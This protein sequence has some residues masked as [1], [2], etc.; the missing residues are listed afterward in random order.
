[1]SLTV[2]PIYAALLAALLL[3]LS[4]RVVLGRFGERISV[5]DGDSKPLIKRMRVQANFVEY[6]PMALI[7][8]LLIELQGAPGWFLHIL[9]L[10]LLG[11]RILHAWGLGHTPQIVPLR[12]LGM[13]LTA[14]MIASGIVANLWLALG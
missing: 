8:L 1:M 12:R 7:L 11:G 13:Y 9:G 10:T 4:I 6:T 5:G 3:I 14:G 2:T